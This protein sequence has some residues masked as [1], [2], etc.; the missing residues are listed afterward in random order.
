MVPSRQTVDFIKSNINRHTTH[1]EGFQRIFLSS[2]AFLVC[3]Q[4]LC[5][6]RPFR[7]NWLR[8]C[9]PLCSDMNLDFDFDE[10]VATLR[11][12]FPCRFHCY[13]N[14]YISSNWI[15]LR[16][17]LLLSASPILKTIWQCRVEFKRICKACARKRTE[18]NQCEYEFHFDCRHLLLLPMWVLSKM[19]RMLCDIWQIECGFEFDFS[20]EGN[21]INFAAEFPANK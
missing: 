7:A 15:S 19:E 13:L 5:G 17:F 18:F 3:R 6:A 1:I 4:A 16:H 2:V 8:A 10:C 12:H 21:W 9:F 11:F 14:F 20:N